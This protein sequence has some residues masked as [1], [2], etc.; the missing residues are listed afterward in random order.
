[1]PYSAQIVM[2]RDETFESLGHDEGRPLHMAG[3]LH[4]HPRPAL[5]AFRTNRVGT[6]GPERLT[7]HQARDILNAWMQRVQEYLQAVRVNHLNDVLIGWMGPGIPAQNIKAVTDRERWLLLVCVGIMVLYVCISFL[8]LPGL[9]WLWCL[10]LGAVAVLCAAL[11]VATG[12]AF[13][14]LVGVPLNILSVQVATFLCLG[15]CMED[16]VV[17]CSE[18]W[19]G[20]VWCGVVWCGV[21]WCGVVWCGVVWCGVVWCGV[22]WLFGIDLFHVLSTPRCL[23]CPPTIAQFRIGVQS[24]SN[25]IIVWWCEIYIPQ[26]PQPMWSSP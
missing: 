26:W 17:R 3:P 22:V 2:R 25:L 18:V 16:F 8:F 6:G 9:P 11:A 7:T 20:V 19:C 5:R 1:M 4:M 23:L 13:A 14:S 10:T 24:E 12:L 15:H 21:V